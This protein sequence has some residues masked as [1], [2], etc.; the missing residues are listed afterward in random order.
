MVKVQAQSHDHWIDLDRA[1]GSAPFRSANEPI[2]DIL[3]ILNGDAAALS[4]LQSE[5]DQLEPIDNETDVVILPFVPA[6]FR[7]FMLYE[8]HVI[9]ASRGF[10]KRFMPRM[11]PITH[12][13]ERLTGKPFR[14][15]RP[16][17][18]WY[19]Q[20]I[21]YLSNHLNIGISGD[22][23]AWPSYTKALDYELEIGAMISKPLFNATPEE[24]IAAIGG[25]VVLNDFSARDIQRDEMDS[26][27]GPQKAKHFVSTISTEV[28]TADEVLP[29]LDNLSASVSINGDKVADCHSSGMY[30]DLGQAIAFASKDEQLH[31]GELF[32]TGTLPGGGGMENDH[33]LSPGDTVSL[34]IERIGSLTNTIKR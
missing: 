22:D 6:S 10:V 5:L 29:Y 4:K 13:I 17:A 1:A 8:K 30:H 33:W 27:F 16:H 23:I 26:G 34:Q 31:P 32:G 20:P 18:L 25:F 19:Q 7:D 21:Y 28:I 14:K 11:L 12:F 3:A 15:F 9:D 24:A 2:T